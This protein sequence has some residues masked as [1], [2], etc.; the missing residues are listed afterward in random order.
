MKKL[1]LTAIGA[2]TILFTQ[3]QCQADFS[4]IQNGP[5]TIFT[6]LILAK[7]YNLL[8]L[9]RQLYHP[10]FLQQEYLF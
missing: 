4:Y 5:T 2:L 10:K 6:A 9:H 3:A 1:F 7:Y 8:H